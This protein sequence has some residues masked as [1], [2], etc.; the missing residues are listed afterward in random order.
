MLQWVDWGKG[1]GLMCCRRCF[2]MKVTE[3][4][5]ETNQM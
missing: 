1:E 2:L 4:F 5:W 3:R